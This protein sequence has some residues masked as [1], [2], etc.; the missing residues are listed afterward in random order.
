MAKK[1]RWSVSVGSTATSSGALTFGAGAG[2]GKGQQIAEVLG[3]NWAAGGSAG[4]SVY[5]RI[6]ADGSTVVADGVGARLS[7]YAADP[8]GLGI[9]A[10]NTLTFGFTASA[11]GVE[12]FFVWGEWA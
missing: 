12:T 3:F 1:N 8:E 2:A 5:F 10:Q 9:R 6:V 11:A 4:S 7:G